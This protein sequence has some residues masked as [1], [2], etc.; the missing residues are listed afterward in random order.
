MI[1][2]DKE[3]LIAY[4]HKSIRLAIQQPEIVRLYSEY[5]EDIWQSSYKLK[6]GN[7]VDAQKFQ[8]L[9]SELT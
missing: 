8:S 9:E 3:L 2:D 7:K 4:P 6:Q 5:F 1:I